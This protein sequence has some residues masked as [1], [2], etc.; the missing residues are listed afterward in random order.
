MKEVKPI[1]IVSGS[2][3]PILVDKICNQL[4]I[5]PVNATI[6]YLPDGESRIQFHEDMSGCD[7]YVIQSGC[8]PVN[9]NLM[10]LYLILDILKRSNCWRVT[11]CLPY[12]PYRKV[13]YGAPISTKAVANLL[14][15]GG[16]DRVIT[17]D[18][19]NIQI[20]GF[21]E[22]QVD[23]LC[24]SKIFLHHMKTN[25]R[26]HTILLSP[27]TA[28]TSRVYKY[29][30]LL[31]LPMA[32][33]YKKISGRNKIEQS[34]ILGAVKNQHVIVVDDIST[35]R[36][37]CRIARIAM[38]EGAKSVTCYATHAELSW[39]VA[40][41]IQESP[42]ER[43]YVTDT[44]LPLPRRYPLSYQAITNKIQRVSVAPLIAEAIS[45]IHHETLV[46]T[47]SSSIVD[48]NLIVDED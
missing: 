13:E 33:S 37:I 48:D 5:S 24:G 2:S 36:T 26:E 9:Y 39:E 46:N 18:L 34:I 7:V 20:Q 1:K 11:C 4:G 30:K 17:V 25:I 27:D 38:D 14:T 23:N 42:I 45:N 6:K 35:A 15:T 47:P 16:V 44:I 40:E 41:R 10:E 19:H 28:G 8:D 12:F 21:F 3:N 43:V 29:S 32:T 22:C 31:D